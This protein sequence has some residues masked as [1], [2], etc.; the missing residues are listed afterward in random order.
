[1]TSVS[2]AAAGEDRRLSRRVYDADEVDVYIGVLHSTLHGLEAAESAL[3]QAE[4]T[5]P[6]I[7]DL[8]STEAMLGQL[9]L[10]AQLEADDIITASEAQVA[11][12]L[13][14]AND[15]VELCLAGARLEA[16]R[17]VTEARRAIESFL[18]NWDDELCDQV[19][20]ARRRMF[21][22][23]GRHRDPPHAADAAVGEPRRV[24]LFD[25]RA[26]ARVKGRLHHR[27]NGSGRPFSPQGELVLMKRSA[28][29]ES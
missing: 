13:C 12:I 24:A 15:E 26:Q 1:L 4:S 3:D 8:R 11:A 22:G 16:E 5:R 7:A 2:Y 27:G 17:L 21:V 23:L 25:T 29:S 9:L 28:D 14:R 19:S 18:R 10:A 6:S 20:E